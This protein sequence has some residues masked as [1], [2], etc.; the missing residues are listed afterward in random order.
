MANHEDFDI[1][2]ISAEEIVKAQPATT[3]GSGSDYYKVDPKKGKDGVYS[4]VI[5]FVYNPKDPLN[6]SKI[7]KYSYWLKD[8]LTDEGFS[9]DC[10]STV[11]AKSSLQDLYFKLKKSANAAEVKLADGFKRKE[12][13]YSIVQI[14]KDDNNPQLVGQFKIFK[15]GQK[16]NAMLQDE[17]EPEFGDKNNIFD[18]LKGKLFALKA[19][20]QGGYTNY[21]TSKFIGEGAPCV[22]KDGKTKVSTENAQEWKQYWKEACPDLNSTEYK[23]WDDEIKA[24]INE[25]ISNTAPNHFADKANTGAKTSNR[26]ISLETA[27]PVARTNTPSIEKEEPLNLNDLDLG[28]EDSLDDDLYADL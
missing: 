5:R 11:G 25:V 20:L 27:A 13:Y 4:A 10:P 1:F 15:F 9:V 3:Q 26:S 7:K 19:T 23:P 22:F 14:M 18:P 28:G 16:L 17:L 6:K 21:D 24:R 2:N 12:N 8:P